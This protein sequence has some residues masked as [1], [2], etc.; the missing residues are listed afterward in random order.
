MI[1]GILG[2]Q[3]LYQQILT[4]NFRGEYDIRHVT[5]R[6]NSVQDLRKALEG[7]TGY[8]DVLVD[9]TAVGRNVEDGVALLNRVLNTTQC[10]Y[11][12][13]ASGYNAE[14]R[15][16]HDLQ[17]LGIDD[18]DIFLMS[19]STMKSRISALLQ[20][21]AQN[22]NEDTEQEPIVEPIMEPIAEPEPVAEPVMPEVP[23]SQV[24]IATAKARQIH[25]PSRPISHAVTVAITGTYPR[26]GTTTQAFQLLLYLKSQGYRCAIIDMSG[27]GQLQQYG[28]VYEDSCQIGPFELQV[29]NISIMTNSKL[30]MQ[31]RNDYDY[32]LCDYGEYQGII[33]PVGFWEKDI[34]IA[35]AGTKPWESA[36]LQNLFEDEDGSLSYIF[37]FVPSCDHD[38]VCQQMADSA[39]KTFFAPYAPDYFTYCGAD[40]FYSKLISPAAEQPMPAS[41]GFHFFKNKNRKKR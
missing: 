12:A 11:M 35:V 24:D 30:L 17:I 6:S 15:L 21:A 27:S 4:L 3:D 18:E 20:G 16:V 9:L 37:S 39:D 1:L 13:I 22:K 36:R 23:P 32:I 29:Q 8:T 5:A 14:S 28:D 26:I 2:G 38:A 7:D 25:K 10:H 33:D 31:A 34:K 41:K 40:E 19:G